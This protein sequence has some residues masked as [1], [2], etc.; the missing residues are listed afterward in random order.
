MIR[1]LCSGSIEMNLIQEREGREGNRGRIK[2]HLKRGARG[3]DGA[4]W[5]HCPLEA[6]PGRGRPCNS[7]GAD[8]RTL[9]TNVAHGIDVLD[10]QDSH[11]GF[12][13]EQTLEMVDTCCRHPLL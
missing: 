2:C 3:G 7:G 1:E 8:R 10:V 11:T 6:V 9:I 5:D 4:P 12:Y 13:G